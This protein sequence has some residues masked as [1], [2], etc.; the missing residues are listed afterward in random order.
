VPGGRM[1]GATPPTSGRCQRNRGG[2]SSCDGSGP[3]DPGMLGLDRERVV[4]EPRGDLPQALYA[5]G[6]GE[7]RLVTEHGVEDEPLTSL[8]AVGRAELVLLAEYHLRGAEAHLGRWLSGQEVGCDG[9]C[10]ARL[11]LAW[12][13]CRD[14]R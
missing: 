12:A 3:H 1:S 2:Q 8:E 4:Q 6:A 13:A 7:Q 9:N 11:R 10:G 5:V 14:H